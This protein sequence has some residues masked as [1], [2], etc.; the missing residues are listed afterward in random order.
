[1][2]V[3]LPQGLKPLRFN[4]SF[5]AGINACSTP[6]GTV[7][8]F[9]KGISAC[10]WKLAT[11]AKAQIFEIAL[12][13]PEGPLFHRNFPGLKPNDLRS[14]YAANSL[15]SP[16]PEGKGWGRS[17]TTGVLPQRLKPVMIEA[18]T[19]GINACSTPWGTAHGFDKGINACSTPARTQQGWNLVASTPAGV[20]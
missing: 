20:C 9:D 2:S 19:A 17:S 8:G 12:R 10:S 15:R 3:F 1:M 11:R 6:R 14:L 7:H 5:T 16:L 4:N 13:G 18:E